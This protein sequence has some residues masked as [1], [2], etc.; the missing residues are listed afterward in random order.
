MDLHDSEVAKYKCTECELQFITQEKIAVSKTRLLVHVRKHTGEK[1]YACEKCDYK[2][3]INH[4]G[5][6]YSSSFHNGLQ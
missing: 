1:P 4:S 2:C 5:G 3:A 6:R